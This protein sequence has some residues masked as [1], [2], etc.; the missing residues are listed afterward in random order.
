MSLLS[1]LLSL[2]LS[3][4]WY[5]STV[6]RVRLPPNAPA[7]LVDA[8]IEAERAQRLNSALVLPSRNSALQLE[9]M[10][11][12]ERALHWVYAQRKRVDLGENVDWSKWLV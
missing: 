1:P 8:M 6:D 5:S 3:L 9:D 7:A 12:T 4:C 10:D 11:S 2:K